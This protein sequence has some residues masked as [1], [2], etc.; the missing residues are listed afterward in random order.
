MRQRQGHGYG[1]Y[2]RAFAKTL[3]EMGSDT[4]PSGPAWL[5]PEVLSAKEACMSCHL[6]IDDNRFLYARQPYRRHSGHYLEDHPKERF[7]C[8]VC[9]PGVAGALDFAGAGHAPPGDPS[10]RELWQRDFGW[11]APGTEGMVPLRWIGGRCVLCHPGTDAQHSSSS[12]REG[13]S[14]AAEKRCT[15]CHSFADEPVPLVRRAL[16]LDNLGSK[17]KAA[18]LEAYLRA[19]DAFWPSTA[20]P[21]F[22]LEDDE[23]RTMAGYLLSRRDPRI[24]W[25][26]DDPAEDSAAVERGKRIVE[27]RRCQTCHDIPGVEESGFLAHHK[28]GPSLARAGEKLNPVW[29]GSWLSDP[30][31][32]QPDTAMP[33][34]R[35]TDGEIADVTAFLCSLREQGARARA[36]ARE[37]DNVSAAEA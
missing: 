35:W 2:Q 28:I 21:T 12:Y 30:H 29:I 23:V 16:R 19:P 22:R 18:W 1:R 17:V 33:R 25:D 5:E 32:I 27:E 7:G 11:Q 34:F 3:A 36:P 8:T 20:M 15:A 31:A 14:M 6:S 13:R 37:P 24:P 4:P 26:G 9:H 10:R